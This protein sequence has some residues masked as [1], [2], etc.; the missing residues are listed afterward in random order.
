[1]RPVTNRDRAR[2]AE[3]ALR[4]FAAETG[5]SVAHESADCIT[6]LIADLGHVC[7]RRRV[8][9]IG[10]LQRGIGHWWAEQSRSCGDAPLPPVTIT[11]S[12][13]PDP[14]RRALID[15]LTFW[16]GWTRSPR[17]AAVLYK[18]TGDPAYAPETPSPH[19]LS[20]QEGQAP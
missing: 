19:T 1:M 17:I 15:E 5:Q 11:I 9:F 18:A 7:D 13:V 8:D 20:Q 14:I 3:I 10:A 2:R 16:H 6:D 12:P 4:R